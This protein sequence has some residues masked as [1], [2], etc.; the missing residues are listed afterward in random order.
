MNA[1]LNN[2]VNRAKNPRDKNFRNHLYIFLICCGIS[3]FI[4]FLIKMS[5]DYVTDIRIPLAYTNVP[6][7][8]QLNNRGDKLSVRLR[9]NGSDL[10]SV[11]YFS[12]KDK[13]TVNLRQA[14]LRRSRYFD[15][16]YFLTEQF[17]T[18]ISSRYDFDHT[19][20]GISPDTI[21]LDLEEIISRRLPVRVNVDLEFKP[22]YMLYDS[23]S[24]APS[25]IMVSGPASIVD[26]L[27]VIYTEKQKFSGLGSNVTAVIP[28][29]PP[30]RNKTVRYSETEVEL[31]I[32]VEQ[33]TES[34][35]EL[36]V[37]GI[38]DDSGISAIRTFPEKVEVTYRVALKDYPLVKP[39][40]FRLTAFFNPEKDRG[41]TFLRVRAEKQPEFV[42]ITRIEPD[43]VEFI[44]QK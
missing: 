19:L 4:W 11:K 28:I 38:T 12:R 17:S 1:R 26:T 22:Q 42:R 7:D 5:D 25:E 6:A 21:Y 37:N 18:E 13:I 15:K 23:I 29:I 36:P 33:F 32:A 30:V 24:V 14:D 44:I 20:L 40:M 41:K 2:L 35:I 9:A 27:S 16:Y 3:L 43:K 10:F 8:K 31:N 34:S 39:E